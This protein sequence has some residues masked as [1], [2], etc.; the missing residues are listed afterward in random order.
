ME[1]PL[2]WVIVCYFIAITWFTCESNLLYAII[3]CICA[4][5]LWFCVSLLS[6][7]GPRKTRICAIYLLS[8]VLLASGFERQCERVVV[9]CG[10]L[11]V[12]PLTLILYLLHRLLPLSVLL[13]DQLCLLTAESFRPWLH[14]RCQGFQFLFQGIYFLLKEIWSKNTVYRVIFSPCVILA[15]LTVLQSWIHPDKVVNKKRWFE[16]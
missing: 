7:Y 14:F 13:T 15:L 10:E 9:V 2:S 4:A 16:T 11:L 8:A 1:Q 3:F 5:R 12:V 6:F